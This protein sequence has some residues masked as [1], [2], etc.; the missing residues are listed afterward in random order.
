MKRILLSL[1]VALHT[2]LIMAGEEF[3]VGK[4]VFEI[5]SSTEVELIDVDHSISSAYI[6][7][8][9]TYQGI[10]YRVTS[11][12]LSAFDGCSSLTSV[13]IPNSVTSIRYSAF[14]NCFSLTSI[15]IPNSVTSIGNRA[16]NNC[17]SL[18]SVIIPNSVTSIGDYAFAGCSSLTSISI[19]NRVTII[20]EGTF[21]GC[22]LLTSIT[23]PECITSIGLSAFED[24]SSLASITIPNNV[25]SIEQWAFRGTAIYNNPSNWE[26][27][28]LYIN[29]SLIHV[30]RKIKGNYTIKSGTR[31]IAGSAFYACS[32]LTSVTI[33]NSVTSIGSKTF[34]ECSSLTSVTIPNSVTS[35]GWVA[36]YNTGIYNNPSNWTNGALYINNCLIAVDENLVGNYTIRSGTRII[37]DRAFSRCSSLTSIIIPNSVTS[38]GRVAFFECSSLTSVT[39]PNSVTSIGYNAFYRCKSLT[40][41]NYAGTKEQWKRIEKGKVWNKDSTIQI[42][43]CTNGEINL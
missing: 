3:I 7:P 23:I 5:T 27:G 16:F 28:S 31:T 11:I 12:G 20:E 42:I 8:T 30:D 24:C 21:E 14:N 35:I 41:F 36:F 13:T 37:A 9:I 10:T 43:R 39:I 1:Y 38:I 17:S 4:Y 2:I 33:P 6:S 32:S 15:T 40:M 25:T 22:R 26:N 18:T 34:Y 19:P 29:N